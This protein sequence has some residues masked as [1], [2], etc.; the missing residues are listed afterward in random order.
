[1]QPSYEDLKRK[2]DKLVEDMREKGNKTRLTDLLSAVRE[3]EDFFDVDIMVLNEIRD[4]CNEALSSKN[5]FS[6]VKDRV[7]I[8]NVRGL[9]ELGNAA[10][11]L[12]CAAMSLRRRGTPPRQREVDSPSGFDQRSGGS[13]RKSLEDL[14][15]GQ[16]IQ[17]RHGPLDFAEGMYDDDTDDVLSKPAYSKGRSPDFEL[18]DDQCLKDY[19]MVHIDLRYKAPQGFS[20]ADDLFLDG[21][22]KSALKMI[23]HNVMKQAHWTDN[24]LA[25]ES[26]KGNYE[27]WTRHS[28]HAENH[29]NVAITICADVSVMLR[30]SHY[31]GPPRDRRRIRFYLHIAVAQHGSVHHFAFRMQRFP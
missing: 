19:T 15:L 20:L 25:T 17:R 9:G 31:D 26:G 6:G 5:K 2:I 23:F 16:Q 11:K 29:L 14:T 22:E 30:S 4:V 28:D 12:P 24:R 13:H 7:G 1:M 8:L 10:K 3:V 27:L 21:H 18:V